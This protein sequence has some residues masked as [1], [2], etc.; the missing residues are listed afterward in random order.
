MLCLERSPS[1]AAAAATL[2]HLPA[3]WLLFLRLASTLLLSLLSTRSPGRL[4]LVTLGTRCADS[5]QC[6]ISRGNLSP[7]AH[8]SWQPA[9]PPSGPH[10]PRQPPDP[11]LMRPQ[12]PQQQLVL[13]Q[14]VSLT[15]CTH[16]PSELISCAGLQ[17]LLYCHSTALPSTCHPW[18]VPHGRALTVLLPALPTGSSNVTQ[19]DPLRHLD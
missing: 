6:V 11:C 3:P 5:C 4:R 7:G 18:Q 1:C 13:L 10:V 2:S 8:T 17:P 19:S 9:Q 12:P 15:C 14:S 16:P